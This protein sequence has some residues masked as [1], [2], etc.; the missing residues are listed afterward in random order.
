M[1]IALART[2]TAQNYSH[3]SEIA[4]ALKKLSADKCGEIR[5]LISRSVILHKDTT[6]DKSA[7]SL[8]SGSLDSTA[9]NESETNSMMTLDTPDA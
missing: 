2:L 6:A 3:D 5:E 9:L 4:A 8:P 1:R 7:F